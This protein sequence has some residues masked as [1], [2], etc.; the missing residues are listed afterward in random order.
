MGTTL[1]ESFPFISSFSAFK[2]RLRLWGR[3]SF[4]ERLPL[5]LCSRLWLSSRAF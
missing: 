4:S 3:S 1:I 5:P 2:V